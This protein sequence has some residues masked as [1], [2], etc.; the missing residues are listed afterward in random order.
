M[1]LR[2]SLLAVVLLGLVP[3]AEAEVITFD[4]AGQ[5][6]YLE[7]PG[8][9]AGG[10][11]T[12]SGWFSYDTEAEDAE[13]DPQTGMYA[14]FDYSIWFGDLEVSPATV[15]VLVVNDEQAG[16]MWLDRMAVTGGGRTPTDIAVNALTVGL[17][18]G[19]ATVFDSDAL[20][21]SLAL[22]DFGTAVGLNVNLEFPD[23]S[24]LYANGTL[25]TLTPEP[26]SALLWVLGGLLVL[27]PRPCSWT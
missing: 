17:V 8:G 2:M 24:P 11:T 19:S 13:P 16:Y 1:R 18:D 12:F 6:G 10:A 3:L 25:T 7:D 14:G 5:L 26:T 20:P 4:F 21:T 27:R 9:Y 15:D 23:G 22:E